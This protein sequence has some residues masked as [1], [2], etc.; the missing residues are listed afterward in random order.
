M[1]KD[2][3]GLAPSMKEINGSTSFNKFYFVI[4]IVSYFILETLKKKLLE[5]RQYFLDEEKF[6]NGQ[7]KEEVDMTVGEAEK[8]DEVS[9]KNLSID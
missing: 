1:P 3:G 5:N 6:R 2:Y 7:V 4:I 9:F 8:D